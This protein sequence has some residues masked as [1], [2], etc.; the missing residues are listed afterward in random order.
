[1]LK[2]RDMDVDVDFKRE[3]WYLTTKICSN[4]FHKNPHKLDAAMK[5][6][7]KFDAVL[8]VNETVSY[9]RSAEMVEKL[10]NYLYNI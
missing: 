5:I 9:L 8:N 10:K 3:T 2:P 7:N 4:F 1:V 6:L